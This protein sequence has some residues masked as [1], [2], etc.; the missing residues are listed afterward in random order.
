MP[1]RGLAFLVAVALL[2]ADLRTVF[3]S[4]PPP[5]DG[6]PDELD[7]SASG[8]RSPSSCRAGARRRDGWTVGGPV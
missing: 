4:L 7:P 2:G 6:I 1:R 5:L 3:A 8:S